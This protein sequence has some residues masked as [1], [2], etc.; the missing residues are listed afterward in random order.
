MERGQEA[1]RAC[2]WVNRRTSGRVELAGND[3]RVGWRGP[4][5]RTCRSRGFQNRIDGVADL[6]EH[7]FAF[8]DT[9]QHAVGGRCLLRK[10]DHL[11]G[12][13]ECRVPRHASVRDPGHESSLGRPVGQTSRERLDQLAFDGRVLRQSVEACQT[14]RSQKRI[15]TG[16]RAGLM[17]FLLDQRR[18]G[19]A[20]VGARLHLMSEIL[21][22]G[23]VAETRGL[24]GRDPRIAACA[25][26]DVDECLLD[27]MTGGGCE[28]LNRGDN[29]GRRQVAIGGRDN[30]ARRSG[31]RGIIVVLDV[32]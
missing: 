13:I 28:G 10:N 22:S 7:H 12:K 18:R 14:V 19:C 6:S 31:G 1:L 5:R 4:G 9:R 21:G 30:E 16:A 2:G 11:G 32:G 20:G 23:A 29:C 25:D 17:R 3:R 8:C 26:V 24:L 15:S 27:G